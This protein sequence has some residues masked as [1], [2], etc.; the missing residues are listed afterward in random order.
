[1]DPLDRAKVFLL[2]DLCQ[3]AALQSHCELCQINLC[4]ACV[5]EHLSDSSKRHNVVP[6]KYR[7][8][9]LSYPSV[10]PLLDEQKLL[11]TIDT[12]LELLDSVT[13]LNDEKV[14]TCG[15]D[16]IIQLFNIQ[17]RLKESIQTE[18]WHPERGIAVTKSGDL[19]CIDQGTKTVNIVKNKQIQEVIRLLRRSCNV[20]STSSKYSDD[21]RQYRQSKVVRYSQTDFKEKQSI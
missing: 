15:F 14:W 16:N 1:M 3:R 7:T 5:G 2:C 4:K 9:V 17:G 13:R 20:C 11:T 18:F 19:V 10:K 12:G 6:Y 21:Y 8:K